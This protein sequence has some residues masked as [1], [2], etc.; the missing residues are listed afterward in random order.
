MRRMGISHKFIL[1]IA[2]S[3]ALFL[4]CTLLISQ[5]IMRRHALRTADELASTILDRT[6]MQIAQFFGDMEYL[7]LG[8]AGTKQVR[9][10]NPAGMRDV[11][12][13]TVLAR[14]RYLRAIY[15]GTADGRMYEWG[16]GEGFIDN[17]P[18]FPPDYDPR[19][20]PWYLKGIEND[21]F[22]ISEPYRYASID[23][24][25]ITCVLPVFGG[26]G[27]LIGVLGLDILLDSLAG[28]LA[29]LQIPKE[30]KAAILS[31]DGLVVASQFAVHRHEG[32]MLKSFSMPGAE[33][34]RGVGQGS[35]SSQVD[36][37]DT[38]FAF[39]HVDRSGW[40]I[41]VGMPYGAI[42][43]S[44][45]ELLSAVTLFDL[46]M[47][48]AML[49]AVG[50]IMGKLIVA[51][52]GYIVSVINRKEGGEREARAII[53]SRD[54]FEFLGAELNKLFDAVDGYSGDLEDKVRLR[55]EETWL[56]QK[57]NTRLRIAEERK[58][59]YRDMHDSIGARLTNIF[60]C[61]GVARDMAKD[62]AAPLAAPLGEMFD[63]IET[64]CLQ[65]VQNLKRIIFGMKEDA[66]LG[67]DTAQFLSM[68]IRQRL[69]TAGLDFDCRITGREALNALPASVRGEVEKVFEELVSNVL[70]H[71][72]ASGVR[73][74]LKAGRNGLRIRFA[75]DGRGFAA[76][77]RSNAVSGLNNIRYR[78]EGL[79][80]S[81][82]MESGAA[83][84][85][86]FSIA[87]PGGDLRHE[88]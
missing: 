74:R 32:D 27:I 77:P 21:G 19:I 31:D 87:I 75:D 14:K 36:G 88:A 34:M 1:F 24:L 86:V 54:E 61:N 80:G 65:A 42:L 83:S 73:L 4:V 69:K 55:T 28:I 60:F 12:L 11:F 76:L 38:Y 26:D 9:D 6:D 78:I 41:V 57:E 20:R 15:L 35:F 68:G 16:S 64:N 49:L 58:R 37:V 46:I 62:C 23:A 2:A 72:K 79:G 18:T 47:M 25:G 59:I 5:N 17:T 52:L 22:S 50:G 70:K 81:M 33:A 48:I 85:T 13:A 71:A 40:T 67:Q 44:T 45:R 29:D 84:G 66:L 10:V 63:G 7:A 53:K 51:P 82:S 43:A 39:R 3:V 30:G 8:L 56:L